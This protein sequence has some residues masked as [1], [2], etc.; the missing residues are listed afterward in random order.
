MSKLMK[1]VTVA[2]FILTALGVLGWGTLVPLPAAMSPSTSTGA[3]SPAQVA[4]AP[5]PP[6]LVPAILNGEPIQVLFMTRTGDTV[7]VRCYPGYEP[8]LT[9]RG[10]GSDP[11]GGGQQEGVLTCTASES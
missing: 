3:V 1:V 6:T 8:T 5:S 4:T 9:V 11:A 7:L 2:L 10:M